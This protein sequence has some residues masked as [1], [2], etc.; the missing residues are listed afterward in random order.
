RQIEEFTLNT[1][2]KSA[3]FQESQHYLGELKQ[4][5]EEYGGVVHEQEFLNHIDS[6]NLAQNHTHFLLVLG[7][8]FT[9]LK[10]GDEFHHRWTVDVELAR[11][12]EDCLRGV[13]H[14]LDE[15]VLL[16]ESEMIETVLKKYGAPERTEAD[17]VRAKR[18][19]KI[20][21]D[22]D[23]SPVGEWGL[24]RSPNVRVRGIRDYAFLVLRKHGSPM[25]FREVAKAI[26]TN[27]SKKANPAT[28]HNELI[29]DKRFVLVGRGIYALAEWGY[30]R[31]V[32]RDVIKEI[33]A[34]DG[35]L[36]EAQ[37]LEKVMKERHVKPNT[38]LVNLKNPKYFKKDKSGKYVAV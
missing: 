35:P 18:W 3:V 23:M 1:I 38:I 13:C 9:K 5:M 31:G 26:Q 8:A 28:C 29:K 19:L 36:P 22:I 6:N 37:V 4:V 21:K 16:P 33:L 25:H 2:R 14:D 12:I 32:V 24:S 27:F 15:N 34:S 11:R 17:K 10:E 7:G 30:T 20:S